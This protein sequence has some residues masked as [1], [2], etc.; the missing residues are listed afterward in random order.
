MQLYQNGQSAAILGYE[1]GGDYIIVVFK[2]GKSYKYSYSSCGRYH[3]ERMIVLA[4]NDKD[5]TKYIGS[6]KSDLHTE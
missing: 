6:N 5:L 4:E 2:D 1:I 3:V